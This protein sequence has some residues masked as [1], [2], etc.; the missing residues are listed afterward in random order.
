MY[1]LE[2]SLA[3]IKASTYKNYSNVKVIGYKDSNGIIHSDYRPPS[4]A[5]YS[6]KAPRRSYSL[7]RNDTKLCSDC[8]MRLEFSSNDTIFN[9]LWM[10]TEIAKMKQNASDLR[11]LAGMDGAELEAFFRVSYSEVFDSIRDNFLPRLMDDER[12]LRTQAANYL[13]ADDQEKLRGICSEPEL[14]SESLLIF[15][16][17]KDWAYRG[18][19]LI[20]FLLAYGSIGVYRKGQQSVLITKNPALKSLA[21]Y[22]TQICA[23]SNAETAPEHIEAILQL[24]PVYND[25]TQACHAAVKLK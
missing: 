9:F 23:V 17:G 7:G 19:K 4:Q 12:K 14:K 5:C 22:Q 25:F 24:M 2:E 10:H 1:T 11:A 16:D 3:A 18:F 15:R 20:D 21:S 8:V 6:L 13:L